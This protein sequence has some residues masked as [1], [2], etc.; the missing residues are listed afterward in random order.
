MKTGVVRAFSLPLNAIVGS[1]LLTFVL[2]ASLAGAAFSPYGPLEADF[3]NRFALPS[4]KHWFGTD[5]Y[6]RDIFT[7]IATGTFISLRVSVAAVTA[8]VIAGTI[9]GAV[10]GYFGTWLDRIAVVIL[11]SIM[12]FPGLLLVLGIMAATGP[13]EYGIVF[14]L[15]VAYTPPIARI[16][17]GTFYSLKEK[18]YVTASR[19]IGNSEIVTMLR[20]VLPNCATPVI[21]MSTSIFTAA[22]LSE[23]ALSFLGLGVPP[24]APSWGSL[25]ADSRNYLGLNP[26]MGIF[27]GL[28]VTVT[29]LSVNLIGDALRDRWDLR[30]KALR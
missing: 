30:M 14:A 28:A 17:R 29:L 10:A 25:L 4:A 12:A 1:S 5:E 7:R 3:L 22:V 13:G 18:E 16:V 15:A 23:A 11:D 2:I 24:P 26:W 20:H 19:L 27:P 8:A 21:V 9:I 6:G